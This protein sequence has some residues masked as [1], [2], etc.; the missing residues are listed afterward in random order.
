MEKEIDWGV[1]SNTLTWLSLIVVAFG[2]VVG[3]LVQIPSRRAE[4]R[5]LMQVAK[6]K[7]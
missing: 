6:V 1:I 4:K 7:D 5:R 3:N 2:I